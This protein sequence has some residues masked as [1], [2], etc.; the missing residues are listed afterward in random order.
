[1]LLH[2]LL[3]QA[4]VVAEHFQALLAEHLLLVGQAVADHTEHQELPQHN[5]VKI[6]E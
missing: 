1:M 3:Q 2:Y 5:L 6:L 4:V